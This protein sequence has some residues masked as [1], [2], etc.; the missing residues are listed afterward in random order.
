MNFWAPNIDRK[1]RL[2]RG[3]GALGMFLG[4]F[5]LWR[6]GVSVWPWVLGVSALFVL[7]EALRGWCVVRACKIKTPF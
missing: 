3:I 4:A 2:L 1:G 6:E 5:L 7:F